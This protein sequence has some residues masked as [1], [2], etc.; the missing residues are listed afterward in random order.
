M[1]G[2]SPIALLGSDL[3]L[4]S[5]L[6]PGAAKWPALQ[7]D[8]LRLHALRRVGRR[9][10][11]C[12][13]RRSDRCGSSRR[14]NAAGRALRLPR[15]HR[16]RRD[17]WTVDDLS[18]VERA[19]RRRHRAGDRRAATTQRRVAGPSSRLVRLRRDDH[20][21]RSGG[22]QSASPGDDAR[23]RCH[24]ALAR[25]LLDRASRRR[26]GARARRLQ[27]SAGTA[28]T[29]RRSSSTRP[30]MR[31]SPRRPA[32]RRSKATSEAAFSRQR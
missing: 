16:N 3:N 25:L 8:E 28:R 21:V 11:Q 17:G 10:R 32:C 13:L 9:R 30:P 5:A 1:C 23:G 20:S 18:F 27:P 19:H 7:G 26:R 4:H 31:W 14:A 2:H 12:G 15:R 29:P 6:L 22:S 24:L